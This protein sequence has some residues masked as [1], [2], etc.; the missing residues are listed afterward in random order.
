MLDGTLGRYPH[1]QFHIDIDPDA[2]SVYSRLY[3]I[4]SIHLNTFKREL[5][6]FVKIGVLT[7]QNKSE[8][9]CPTFIIPK[10]DDRI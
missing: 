3:S 7:P 5:E 1:K 6:N 4:P 2:K 8:W 9:A 10:K